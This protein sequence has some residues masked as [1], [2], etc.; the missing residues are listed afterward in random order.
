VRANLAAGN[1]IYDESNS[2]YIEG[3]REE[4]NSSAETDSFEIQ[5]RQVK[6]SA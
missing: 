2:N 3:S 1:E 4:G 5:P 6:N